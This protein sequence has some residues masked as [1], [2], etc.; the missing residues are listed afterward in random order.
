MRMS[1]AR[2]TMK[3]S[4]GAIGANPGEIDM[5]SRAM[6]N[7]SAHGF[8]F[9]YLDATGWVRA[10]RRSSAFAIGNDVRI[11]LLAT[12]AEAKTFASLSTV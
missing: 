9:S 5:G 6:R 10:G 7:A 2:V 8:R 12:A 1:V 4:A 3:W 11:A